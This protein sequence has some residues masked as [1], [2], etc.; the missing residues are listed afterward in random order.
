MFVGIFAVLLNLLL[1][2]TLINQLGYIGLPLATSLTSLFSG[3][4]LFYLLRKINIFTFSYF[5][6][7]L[8]KCLVSSLISLATVILI[9]YILRIFIIP[10]AYFIVLILS[11]LFFI[12]YFIIAFYF[13]LDPVINLVSYL[14]KKIIFNKL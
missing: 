9:L 4:L 7:I 8:I 11:P 13:K 5:S 12:T 1:N 6:R 14:K 3:I 2:I 10:N